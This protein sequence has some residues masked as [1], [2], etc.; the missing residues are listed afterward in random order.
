MCNSAK[1]VSYSLNGTEKH[2][3]SASEIFDDFGV[4]VTADDIRNNPALAIEMAGEQMA[5]NAINK[6]M[7]A[8]GFGDISLADFKNDPIGA[9][10][11]LLNDVKNKAIDMAKD[12]AKQ[13]IT[14]YSKKAGKNRYY[15]FEDQMENELRFRSEL[16]AGI[17]AGIALGVN[18]PVLGA[19][20]LGVFTTIWA[21]YYIST[22]SGACVRSW[23]DSWPGGAAVVL[24]L[25]PPASSPSPKH[26]GVRQAGRQ[27]RRQRVVSVRSALAMPWAGHVAHCT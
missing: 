20:L 13:I 8:Y 10:K 21:L 5:Q 23:A 27:E 19:H 3:F 1:P 12:R 22:Q 4:T 6:Q 16:E 24:S 17:R 26:R 9:S 7:A 18:D 11:K 15:W 2:C 25:T 14:D